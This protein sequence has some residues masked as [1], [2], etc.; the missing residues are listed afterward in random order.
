M[1]MRIRQEIQE[2]P[3]S[4]DNGVNQQTCSWLVVESPVFERYTRQLTGAVL[5]NDRLARWNDSLPFW[6]V[7]ALLGWA[8]FGS[9]LFWPILHLGIG[10]PTVKVVMYLILAACVQGVVT[11]WLFAARSTAANPSGRIR[12]RTGAVAALILLNASLFFYVFIK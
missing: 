8:V 9:L 3:R 2:V 5:R 10:A 7:G 1:P 6:F 12:M 4:W 11:P